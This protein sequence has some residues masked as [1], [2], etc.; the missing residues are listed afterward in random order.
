MIGFE[1]I[2]N[3]SGGPPMGTNPTRCLKKQ[4]RQEVASVRTVSHPG[5]PE[6]GTGQ[7]NRKGRPE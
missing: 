5:P 1:K 2:S 4:Q 7:Q 6:S 3:I